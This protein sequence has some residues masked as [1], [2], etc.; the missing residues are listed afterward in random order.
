MHFVM[1][2][3]KC[4]CVYF[5]DNIHVFIRT[6]CNDNGRCRNEGD[7]WVNTDLCIRYSCVYNKRKDRVVIRERTMGRVQLVTIKNY[8]S[9]YIRRSL[10]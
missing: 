4:N 3:I 5:Y 1:N 7:M 2:E 8:S 10:L 9:R 6:G